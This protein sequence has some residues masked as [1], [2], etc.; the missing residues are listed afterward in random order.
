MFKRICVA[1]AGTMGSGIALVAAQSGIDTILF[2]LD[3]IA[4]RHAET[5]IQRNL[6]QRVVKGGVSGADAAIIWNNIDFTSDAQACIAEFFIEAITEQLSAKTRLLNLFASFNSAGAIFATN[7]SSLSISDIQ[8]SVVHPERVGGMHFFNPAP[9]MKLVEVVRGKQTSTETATA[10]YE[11][12]IRMGKKPVHCRDSPGFIVNRVARHYY[13]EAMKQVESGA[14]RMEEVDQLMESL[15]FRMGPFKLMD[16]IGIDI[17]YAVSTGIY[18]AF[19]HNERFAPS[20]LQAEK[21]AK[22][23]LGRKTG[24]GFY[25]YEKDK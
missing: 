3:P 21:I 4:I 9:V 8:A 19:D 25:A 24:K 14:A 6:D 11:L 15:G 16:L 18:N 23:D 20:A 10:I 12:C 5:A 13:L 17:N 2:D 1:G 22:G 7:T